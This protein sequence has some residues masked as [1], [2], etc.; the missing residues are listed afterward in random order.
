MDFRTHA[1][2]ILPLGFALGACTPY[3]PPSDPYSGS[4][5]QAPRYG[6][7]GTE[8]PRN[9]KYGWEEQQRRQQ[10]EQNR[11]GAPDAA[12]NGTPGPTDPDLA[13]TDPENGPGGAPPRNDNGNTPSKPSQGG[14]KLKYGTPV[15]GKP[16]F[17]YSP[18]NPDGGYID[19]RVEN[20]DGSMGTLPPGTKIKDPFSSEP[21]MVP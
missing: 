3:P 20:S 4:S 10:E 1:L 17:L 16:G 18:H 12:P 2:L 11:E 19:I 15:P 6:H 5:A 13:G 8:S 21:I 9:P 14:G 7:D